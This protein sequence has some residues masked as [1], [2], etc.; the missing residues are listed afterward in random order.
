MQTWARWTP[1]W[2]NILLSWLD[3]VTHGFQGLPIIN[4]FFLTVVKKPFLQGYLTSFITAHPNRT[5]RM[6]LNP[7]ARQGWEVS[8]TNS[9]WTEL[10]VVEPKIPGL[11]RCFFLRLL[12]KGFEFVCCFLN[13]RGCKRKPKD[14]QR[15]DFWMGWYVKVGILWEYI[16]HGCFCCRDQRHQLPQHLNK[17]RCTHL[18]RGDY[19]F[20]AFQQS[21]S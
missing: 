21:M 4:G 9:S 16:Q 2:R 15:W 6:N 11:I 18:A 3:L 14:W 10:L 12:G 1:C 19:F 7:M 13:L 20:D 8:V 17:C 5:P